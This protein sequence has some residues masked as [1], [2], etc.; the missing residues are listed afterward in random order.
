MDRKFDFN[1]LEYTLGL[2]TNDGRVKPAGRVF[3][4]LAEA[5]AASRSSIQ[6]R[7]WPHR[8]RNKPPTPHGGGYSTGWIG[9]PKTPDRQRSLRQIFVRLLPSE[10]RTTALRSS[11]RDDQNQARRKLR[12]HTRDRP[13]SC[14]PPSAFDSHARDN[15]MAAIRLQH[16]RKLRKQASAPDLFPR[17]SLAHPPHCETVH[18]FADIS[19][20]HNNLMSEIGQ[21]L[22]IFPSI[23]RQ[24]PYH[25]R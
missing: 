8:L 25:P 7:V 4:Q 5:I 24:H 17:K 22:A 2:L 14:A 20:S 15:S 1:P 18:P 9:S 19:N 6:R 3:K 16:L 13:S 23:N 21:P 10:C 11:C 12:A